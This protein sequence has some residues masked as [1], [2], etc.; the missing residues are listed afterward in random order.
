M[1]YETPTKDQ[2]AYSAADCLLTGITR[3]EINGCAAQAL[4][5]IQRWR[6][7]TEDNSGW[8][9]QELSEKSLKLWDSLLDYV[10]ALA[11]DQE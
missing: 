2:E 4:E 8:D 6:D 1:P 11:R 3:L 5:F 10:K 7:E 9:S